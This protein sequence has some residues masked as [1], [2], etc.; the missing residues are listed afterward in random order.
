VVCIRDVVYHEGPGPASSRHRLDL[1]L[2]KGVK[3]YPVVLLVHGG[4]WVMGDNRSCG[5]Y[6]SVGEFLARRGIGAVLPNYRLSPGVRHPE[7]IRDVARAFAWTHA[8]I[9]AY[10]GRTDQLF[11][12]GHSAGGHLVALLATDDSYLKAEGLAPSDVK[13][14]ITL[15]GLYHIPAAATAYT[16][17]G[18]TPQ[19]FHFRQMV[20][21]R[22]ESSSPQP[23]AN[24]GIPLKVDVYA[25]AFGDDPQAR[26]AASPVNHVRPGLPPFL[27]FSAENDLPTLP[28]MAVEFHQ[29]LR[30][31]G[32]E[33]WLY[34]V[35]KRNHN[36]ILFRAIE[37][38]DPVGREM[39]EFIRRHSAVPTRASIMGDGNQSTAR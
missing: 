21:L 22:G 14:V 24:P 26:A 39:V 29:A 32:C 36:S 23:G 20:P 12:A 38:E 31:Q 11:L 5:L 17:G 9:A 1:F 35:E 18:P 25:L 28:A 3:D 2:P 30:D 15:S 7:H 6:S 27:I 10:G 34:R 13:G 37:A 33:T 8:H 16:L 4:A 19:A